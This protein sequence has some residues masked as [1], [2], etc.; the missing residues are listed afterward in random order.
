M[1][2]LPEPLRWLCGIL[3]EMY[4]AETVAELG[5]AVIAGLHDRFHLT[6]VGLEEL[7]HD[8]SSYVL[9]AVRVAAPPPPGYES[10]I[11]DHPA[12]PVMIGSLRP[13]TVHLAALASPGAWSQTDHYH[14]LARPMGWRDQFILI[15]RGGQTLGNCDVMRDRP[16]R[17]REIEL[18]SVL[19]PHFE[20]AW[21]RVQPTRAAASADSLPAEVE[22]DAGIRPLAVSPK[23]ARLIQSYFA[24]SGTRRGL[25]SQLVEW[26]RS[27]T[28]GLGSGFALDPLRALVAEAPHG[29][30]LVRF[31]PKPNGGKFRFI[32]L[33]APVDPFVFRRI[34]LTLRE[35][36]VLHWIGQ[37][38]RDSEIAAIIGCA[39]ATVSKHVE[40]I[41][42][43][44]AAPNRLAAVAE[45]QRRLRSGDV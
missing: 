42:A 22:V 20:A 44:L 10:C 37:G 41:L 28:A 24:G 8:G 45:A 19:Q 1:G 6:A 32:E 40:H 17:D 2:T 13:L 14:G 12:L 43:K 21:T 27:V 7:G 25:P 18:L 36:D 16:F 31:F 30:L 34:G 15:A 39:Q 3:R 9:H 38:K 23:V 4:G 33:P 11:H 35:C 26:V 5:M 29:K